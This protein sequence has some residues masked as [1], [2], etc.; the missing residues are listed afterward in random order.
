MPSCSQNPLTG[1]DK[2]NV[3]IPPLA[4]LQNRQYPET[5]TGVFVSLADFEDKPA[6]IDFDKQANDGNR[7]RGFKQVEHFSIAPVDGKKDEE[8][9]RY[10]NL[11]FAVNITRT[12]AGAME[13]TLPA[14]AEL[15][16]DIPDIHDFTSYTLLSV[17][18]YSQSIRDDLRLTLTSPAGKW[19][20]PR[21]LL[22]PGWN[23]A[24]IDIRRLASQ[25]NFDATDVRSMRLGFGEAAGPVTFYL[26]D[27][28]LIDN[29]RDI[30]N[31][32]D[33][34][35]L[36][37]QGLDYTLTFAN[38][39][40]EINIS[41]LNDGLWRLGKHQENIQFHESRNTSN[42]DELLLQQSG[43]LEFMGLRRIGKLK[44]LEANDI[45]LRIANTWYFPSR[46]GEWASMAVRR[47]R[48]EYTFYSDGR[49]VTHCELNNAGG[50]R[51]GGITIRP[52]LKASWA[53]TSLPDGKQDEQRHTRRG[54][55]L[56]IRGRT[57]PIWRW[58]YMTMLC[59]ESPTHGR[60][61]TNPGRIDVSIA[62]RDRYAAGDLDKNRFDESQGCYYLHADQTGR[63]RFTIIPPDGG[64]NNP[65]FRID[66]NFSGRLRVNS[67]GTALRDIV[68]LEDGSA[69]FTIGGKIDS[70]RPVEVYTSTK[71]R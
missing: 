43:G 1:K 19:R 54:N 62:R 64:L 17:A 53:P 24:Q 67:A 34:M 13:V 48:R 32:P 29:R 66:G 63:C 26:D 69:L 68:R 25:G 7:M 42:Q 30:P 10:A 36:R 20:S 6:P 35:T 11:E 16:F 41:R 23:T 50:R 14:G 38:C 3:H 2:G 28:L 22:M 9:N 65:V 46:S 45:R 21:T 56:S 59:N 40:D 61:Y 33:G 27:I 8:H 37:K 47:I 44:I 55:S 71:K 4:V 15:V 60:N 31:T 49:W 39:D 70:P 51:I 12:G 5:T 18:I 58:N 57:G 52:A